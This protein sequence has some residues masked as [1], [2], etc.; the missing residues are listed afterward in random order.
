MPLDLIAD[1]FEFVNLPLFDSVSVILVLSFLVWEIPRSVKIMAEEYTKG[2]YPEGGRIPD[3]FLMLAGLACA[4]FMRLGQN[5]QDVVIFLKTPGVT[6]L[7]LIV[8]VTVPLII[9]LG[10]LKRFFGRME[11]HESLTVFLV[12]G[13]LDLFHTMFFISVAVL[14]IP[15]IGFLVKL[16]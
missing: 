5:G 16:H 10:F 3:F 12:Q 8:L 15:V 1:F 4:I 7:Y 9:S 2:L 14:A 11:R 13:F 6:A